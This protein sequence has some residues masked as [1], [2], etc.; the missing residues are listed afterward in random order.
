MVPLL[1][2]IFLCLVH[3]HSAVYIVD[4]KRATKNPKERGRTE[5]IKIKAEINKIENKG[6]TAVQ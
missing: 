3:H 1:L 4:R 5:L 2:I 6:R